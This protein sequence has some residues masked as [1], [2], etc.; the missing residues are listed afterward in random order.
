MSASSGDG[1]EDLVRRSFD[2]IA[3][4]Y[5]ADFA[6]ELDGKPFDRDLLH[7][8]ARAARPPGPVLELGCGPGHVGRFLAE[9]G[10]P[11]RGLDV[12]LESLRMARRLNPATGFVCGDMRALPVRAAACAGMVAFYSLIY[13]DE[14]ATAAILSELRRAVQPRAPLLLAVHGGEG[15]QR[16]T[17]FKGQPIDITLHHHRPERLAVM[18]VKAGFDVEEVLTRPAYPFEHQT[19]RVYALGRAA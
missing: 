16:Y 13:W 7:R 14:A 1:G 9:A 19:V 8:F 18:L 4:R 2:R 5:A 10:V 17:D 15:A 11:I 3:A 6:D 12:S